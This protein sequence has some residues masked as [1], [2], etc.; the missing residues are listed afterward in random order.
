KLRSKPE[1]AKILKGIT[2]NKIFKQFPKI[3]KEFFLDSG[4]WNHSYL[5]DNI[6]SDEEAVTKY[7]LGQKYPVVH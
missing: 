1:A 7:I 2:G 3:K 4:L 6:G 5:L